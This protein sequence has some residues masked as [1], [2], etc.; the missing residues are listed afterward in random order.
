MLICLDLLHCRP[1]LHF[2]ALL[3]LDFLFELWCTLSSGSAGILR[4]IL[5]SHTSTNNLTD[6]KI[7]PWSGHFR[8]HTFL[9]TFK[10]KSVP[11]EN[12]SLFIPSDST[13]NF[14]TLKIVFMEM[15]LEVIQSVFTSILSP[16]P[17]LLM[18]LLWRIVVKWFLFE[19]LSQM[20]LFRDTC[21]AEVLQLCGVVKWCFL[22]W[23]C[24]QDFII[25]KASVAFFFS[26]AMGRWYG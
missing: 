19:Y 6:I 12:W 5:F 2:P 4:L 25:L 10:V 1:E 13:D 17:L 15:F 14:W 8:K 7:K 11:I 22:R 26:P 16:V 20:R 3:F 21:V 23:V 18:R 9:D 24:L